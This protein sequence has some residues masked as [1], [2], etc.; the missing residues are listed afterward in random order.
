MKLYFITARAAC[1]LKTLALLSLPKPFPKSRDQ[2]LIKEGS[3][4]V[5]WSIILI[6][7]MVWLCSRP[8]KR[9]NNSE[10]GR[11]GERCSHTNLKA[12]SC[13]CN[14]PTVLWVKNCCQHHNIFLISHLHYSQNKSKYFYWIAPSILGSVYHSYRSSWGHSRAVIVSEL[15]KKIW[16]LS[17]V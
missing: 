2:E 3:G 4:A 1:F 14:V 11:P 15:L 8:N 6:T 13:S 9:T 7:V 16:Y 17:S 10:L 12:S 5:V